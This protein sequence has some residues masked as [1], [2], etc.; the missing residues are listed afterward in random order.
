MINLNN[1]A[2]KKIT[3]LLIGVLCAIN[4]DAQD[5]VE[6]TDSYYFPTHN[7]DYSY[8]FLRNDMRLNKAITSLDLTVLGNGDV[9]SM[10]KAFLPMVHNDKFTFDIPLYFQNYSFNSSSDDTD[11]SKNVYNVFGQAIFGFYPDSRWSTSQI[12]EF[13]IRGD[14]Q[15][16][17]ENRGNFLASFTTFRYSLNPNFDI[18]FGGLA[19][20]GWEEDGEREPSI[21]PTASLIWEP[22]QQLSVMVGIPGSA[23]EWSLPGQ[24]ELMVHGL[25]DG[26]EYDLTGAL[27]KQLNKNWAITA[28]YLN[29]GFTD[30][31]FPNEQIS[32]DNST[33][34]F[35]N[36]QQYSKKLQGELSYYINKN[37]LL[38]LKAGYTTDRDLHLSNGET[39]LASLDG[40]DGYFA[41]IHFARVFNP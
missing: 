2:M 13:R 8:Y 19:G 41:G 28:R 27:K 21:V 15:T 3:L 29:R 32:I 31:Y 14:E 4:V 35:N 1:D 5:Q 40:Y 18:M 38:Q 20:V 34:N 11:Y 17:Q 24:T 6:E 7:S 23:I 37:S 9:N 33:L 22:S 30:V 39:E 10:T 25:L 12:F 36:L 16:L 26:D